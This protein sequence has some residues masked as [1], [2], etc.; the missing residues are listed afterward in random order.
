MSHSTMPIEPLVVYDGQSAIAVVDSGDGEEL[1]A[2]AHDE[3]SREG[4]V[5]ITAVAGTEDEKHLSL[6]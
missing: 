6:C 4:V 3:V 2:L 1:V 5:E